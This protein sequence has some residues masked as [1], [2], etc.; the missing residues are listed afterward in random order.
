VTWGFVAIYH[1]LVALAA[2][3]PLT[4]GGFG[5]REA[6]YA[7]LLPHAGV[8]PDDAIAL[9]LLWWAVGALGGLLG[10][11]VYGLGTDRVR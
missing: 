3:V 11:I 4:V 8:A 6:A 9:G 1:P 2:A 7:Y 10:G 5:F